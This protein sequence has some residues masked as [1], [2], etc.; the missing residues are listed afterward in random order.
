MAHDSA[1]VSDA[2]IATPAPS[3]AEELQGLFWKLKAKRVRV[4]PSHTTRASAIGEPCE[5]KLFYSRTAGEMATPH[6]PELQAI[7]D[8]GKELEGFVLREL[9][10]MGVEVVQRERDYHDRPLELTAHSDARIR[11][12]GWPKTLTAEVKGLNPYTAESIETIEDIRTSR[13]HWV[14]KY[15]DQLQTYLHFDGGERGLFVLLNKVSGQ[16]TFIDCPR[17]QAR[18][19]DLLAKAARIRDAVR[20]NEP[21]ARHED[22]DCGRCPFQHV[23]LPNRSFGPGVQIVD[24]E[25]IEQLIQLRM[26]LADAKRDFDAAD[27]ALKKLLPEAEEILVGDF[28]ITGR[29]VEREGY[30]VAPT[31]YL[32]RKFTRIHGGQH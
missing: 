24:S 21:P 9:E 27:R 5:R 17:D 1:A 12:P 25:E 10:A 22:E 4:S 28:A 31:R 13:Q 16:I 18:I 14:R 26:E 11:L 3:P 6:K 20:A 7:F 19:D 23:C 32:T 15:Y 8:L 2:F 30:T 29:W